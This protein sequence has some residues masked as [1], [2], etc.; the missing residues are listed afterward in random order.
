MRAYLQTRR[1]LPTDCGLCLLHILDSQIDRRSAGRC[2]VG[3][4]FLTDSFACQLCLRSHTNSEMHSSLDRPP[5]QHCVSLPVFGVRVESI[6]HIARPR[7]GDS[8]R[9]VLV[10][11]THASGHQLVGDLVRRDESVRIDWRSPGDLQ[12]V[13]TH[14]LHAHVRHR[15]RGC[16]LQSNQFLTPLLQILL[17]VFVP[18]LH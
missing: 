17:P 12:R 2:L 11:V 6:E 8:S 9:S 10:V 18:V 5:L 3:L 4:Y 15:A 1:C 13:G 14:W 7:D 16:C